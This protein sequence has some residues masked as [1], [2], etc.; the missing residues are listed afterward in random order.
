MCFQAVQRIFEAGSRLLEIERLLN[1]SLIENDWLRDLEKTASARIQAVESRHKSAKVGLMTAERQVKELTAKLDK[2]INHSCEL[3]AEISDLKA[4]V[5]EAR[6]GV[7][8]AKHKAQ[9][10]YDQGFEEAVNSFKSQLAQECNKYFLQGWNKALDQARVDDDSELYNLGR[11]HRPFKMG[12]SKE[13]VRQVA[14]D[15]KDPE[16]D[17]NPKD[18]K[19][20]EDSGD[21]E[22][23]QTNDVQEVEDGSDKD[24][25][26]DIISE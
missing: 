25:N 16:A 11:R 17:E 1:E 9:A 26:I 10:Y 8:K 3:R 24:D 12:S 5:D 7:Q 23:I 6:A 20:A 18:P 19:V 15:M 14:K 21:P 2:E 13:P 22:Q 4:E